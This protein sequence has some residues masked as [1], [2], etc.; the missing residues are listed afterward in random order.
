MLSCLSEA[1]A[2]CGTSATS[3]HMKIAASSERFMESF[4]LRSAWTDEG[5]RRRIAARLAWHLDDDGCVKDKC[6]FESKLKLCR[7]ACPEANGATPLAA[8]YK[9]RVHTSIVD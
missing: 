2:A 3:S 4:A 5:P 7:A 6:L 1:R 9:I 8:P